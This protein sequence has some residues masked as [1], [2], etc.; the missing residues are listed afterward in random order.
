MSYNKQEQQRWLKYISGPPA[1]RIPPGKAPGTAI[2]TAGHQERAG[3]LQPFLQYGRGEQ[4]FLPSAESG[5][6]GEL[7]KKDT[8]GF[9]LRGEALAEIHPSRY[10]L[11]CRR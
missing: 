11:R 4:F 5:L 10:V 3:V 6:R 7:G 1:G 9:S 2:S 8:A